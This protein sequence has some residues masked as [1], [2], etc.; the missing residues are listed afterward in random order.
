VPSRDSIESQLLAI[1]FLPTTN[2]LSTRK[3]DV[4]M[5]GFSTDRQRWW[6]PDGSSVRLTTRYFY[7]GAEANH[8]GSVLRFRR[9][10]ESDMFEGWTEQ[11]YTAIGVQL[12]ETSVRAVGVR[13]SMHVPPRPEHPTSDDFSA[14]FLGADATGKMNLLRQGPALQIFSAELVDGIRQLAPPQEG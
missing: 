1:R 14:E 6:G 3:G 2:T 10:E 5:F 9:Q 13:R 7:L 4:T 11:S 8:L 12:G